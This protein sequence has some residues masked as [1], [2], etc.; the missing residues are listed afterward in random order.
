MIG[1]QK[2]AKVKLLYLKGLLLLLVLEVAVEVDIV[3]VWNLRPPMLVEMA[4]KALS[5]SNFFW[6]E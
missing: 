1:K 5:S 4:A 2:S 6:K 3:E